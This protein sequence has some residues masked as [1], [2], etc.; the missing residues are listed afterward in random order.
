MKLHH[1]LLKEMFNNNSILNAY[2]NNKLAIEILNT[3]FSFS[4]QIFFVFFL[5][6]TLKLNLL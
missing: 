2:Y 1:F 5:E 3:I 6:T 4:D